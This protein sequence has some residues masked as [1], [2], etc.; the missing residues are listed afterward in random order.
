M[1][2]TKSLEDRLLDM[3]E[4][5]VDHAL[6]AEHSASSAQ[7]RIV[8]MIKTLTETPIGVDPVVKEAARHGLG[9]MYSKYGYS[10]EEVR[11][12]EKFIAE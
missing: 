3:A 6:D 5:A 11:A 9:V 2:R 12:V 4:E 7:R 1:A 8:A 10:S